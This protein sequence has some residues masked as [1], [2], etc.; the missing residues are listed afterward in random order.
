MNP[1]GHVVVVSRDLHLCAMLL[2]GISS[3]VARVKRD[4][5][6]AVCHSHAQ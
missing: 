1:R 6:S 4:D 2:L 5:M 3:N